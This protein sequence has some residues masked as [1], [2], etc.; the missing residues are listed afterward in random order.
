MH[1]PMTAHRLLDRSIKLYPDKIALIDGDI[2]LTYGQAAARADRVAHAAV[3]LGSDKP[4]AVL[5]YNT[6]RYFEL[7]F[8]LSKSGSIILPLNIR[9]T[10]DEY[11]YILEDSAAETVV[12]QADFLGMIN[13]V[14]T[15]VKTVKNYFIAEGEATADWISGTY[16]DL[17]AAQP[18]APFPAPEMDEN[19][20]VNLYYTSGTTGRPKGVELTHRNIYMNAFTTVISFGFRDAD[21]WLHIAPL[22]HLADAFFIWS[23]TLVGGR[24]VMIRQFEPK[25]VLQT[26]A[27]EKI[28]ATMMVPT[29]V[30]F[31]LDEPGLDDYDLSALAWVMIGGAPMSPAK[32]KR[33]MDRLGCRYISAYGLTETTPLV[34]VG[35]IKDTL[36]DAPEETRLGHLTRT[37]LEAPGVEVRV[38]DFEGRDVPWDGQTVG[39]IVVRG[40]NVMKGYFNLPQETETAIRDGYFHTGDLAHVDQE[41]YILIV[42]RAKDIIISGGENIASV[43]V[44]NALYA[45]PAVL[46]CA[47]VAAPDEKWGEVPLAVVALRDG[48]E[49][50]TEE[51]IDHCR[52]RLARFK[53]PKQFLFMAELPKTGS[54]KI[55]KTELRKILPRP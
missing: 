32:A 35:D 53:V 44:E 17:L 33:M 31:L 8:G 10:E 11:V 55:R 7:Y 43:E 22:F 3:G 34:A 40:D 30:N 15:R 16:E 52:E 26:L 45:H 21:A 51:L 4:I 48:L 28:T 25:A 46:E 36:A 50:Q 12:F 41:G 29:M 1:V 9:L 13:R 5:D 24:H 2:R 54:G 6:H 38:V 14:R 18:D 42:D 19:E 27:Q 49:V 39:E 37:G 20:T 23:V 47:V